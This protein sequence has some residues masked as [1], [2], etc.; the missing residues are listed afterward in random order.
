M[1]V[2]VIDSAA[3]TKKTMKSCIFGRGVGFDNFTTNKEVS[4]CPM[5]ESASMCSVVVSE[6][7][8]VEAVG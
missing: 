3:C 4:S 7:L 5:S 2:A 1:T 8:I 6:L